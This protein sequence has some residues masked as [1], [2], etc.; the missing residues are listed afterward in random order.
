MHFQETLKGY[1]PWM[2]KIGKWT[3][4]V[5][6]SR[7][8]SLQNVKEMRIPWNQDSHFKKS[9]FSQYKS[10]AYKRSNIF[11]FCFDLKSKKVTLIFLCVQA[12]TKAVL[13]S[14]AS[15]DVL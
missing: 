3:D 4:V 8:G 2:L 7:S 9:I 15:V 11:L 12:V 1:N 6:Y 13:L 10:Y 5:R 14:Q